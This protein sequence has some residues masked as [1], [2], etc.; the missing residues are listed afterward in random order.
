MSSEPFVLSQFLELAQAEARARRFVVLGT[1]HF[2]IAL[3]KLGGVTTK[4]LEA[5]GQNPKRV[6]DMIRSAIGVG[7]AVEE[8]DPKLTSRA[9]A[10]LKRA[11]ALVK[12][13]RADAVEERHLLTAI[14]EDNEGVTLRT[15][16]ELGVDVEGLKQAATNHSATPTLDLLSRDL[17]QLALRGKLNPLIGRKPELRRLVRTLARKSKNNPVLVGPAGVG[18]TAIVEGLAQLIATDTLPELSGTRLVEI[19]SSVLVADTT[20]RGQFE[21]RL[22]D[23]LDEIKR[24]ENIILFI[25]ELHTILR[26]GAVE[27]GALDAANILKPALARGDLRLIG[28]T[29]P[30]DYERYITSDPSLERRFQLIEV[31]EPSPDES[32]TILA[33][34]KSSYEAHHR[35]SI[36]PEA[37]EAAVRLSVRA[38]PDRHLPDKAFD[39]LDEAC[40]RARLPTVSAPRQDDEAAIVTADV[41]ATVVEDLLSKSEK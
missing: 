23:M 21:K 22:L 36:T 35:V 17:T 28:A 25:D 6:R 19:S 20:Y 4:A 26:T 10:N 9:T 30:E 15:L 3:T 38:F 18:K 29:T 2:F 8:V 37:V 39:L 34:V 40:A 24:A 33:G 1:P 7:N 16:Q 32:M 12:N 27:G 11:E 13:E 5:Q 41:V 14:L 31:Q